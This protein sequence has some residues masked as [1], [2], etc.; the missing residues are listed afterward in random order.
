M[1]QRVIACQVVGEYVTGDG[2]VIGAVGAHDG[3]L[4]E[5]D[6]TADSSGLWEGTTKTVTFTD[7]LGQNPVNILLT[8]NLLA[9]GQTNVYQ[10]PVPQAAMA[11]A[12]MMGITVTGV[13]VSGEKE[14]VRVATELSRFRVLA[15]HIQTWSGEI[16]VPASAAEQL[17]S[18]IDEVKEL[19][20][21]Q[22]VYLFIGEDGCLYEQ[23][24][25]GQPFDFNLD[26]NGVLEVTYA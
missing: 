6:F 13:I 23:I 4:I 24:Y 10:V 12:G 2:V 8:A 1:S 22:C 19:F 20:R 17:Q 25:T 26:E 21:V 3:V 9:D 18:E 7:A 11:V 14:T 16:D 15:N 5:L